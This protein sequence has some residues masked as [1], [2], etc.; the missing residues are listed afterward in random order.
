M[1]L[2]C[3]S[4]SSQFLVDASKIPADGREVRCASCKHQWHAYAEGNAAELKPLEPEPDGDD[5]GE[6]IDRLI[7]YPDPEAEPESEEEASDANALPEDAFEGDADFM[8]DKEEDE[9]QEDD[10]H[11]PE[12]ISAITP[13][14]APFDESLLDEDESEPPKA[15]LKPLMALAA[16][17]L[18]AVIITSFFALRPAMQGPFGFVYAMFGSHSSEGLAL[19]QVSLRERPSRSKARFTVEGQIVNGSGEVR[20]VPTLRVAMLDHDGKLLMSREYEDASQPQLEAGQ[21]YDFKASNLETA[22][23]DNIAWFV[24]DI[25]NGSELRLRKPA[26]AIPQPELQTQHDES[27]HG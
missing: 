22:S 21:S 26:A 15:S 12:L 25:G 8:Q 7:A 14:V 16:A 3:P 6:E 9:S 2:T 4:C 24:V 13:E 20:P 10:D 19:T 18:L 11:E 27:P 23:R 1:I 17:L 5:A